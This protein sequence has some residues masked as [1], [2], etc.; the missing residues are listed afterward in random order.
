V[1]SLRSVTR[2][3][4]PGQG[5]TGQSCNN[6]RAI[7][8]SYNRLTHSK[9]GNKLLLKELLES[10]DYSLKKARQS[11][12]QRTKSIKANCLTRHYKQS[13]KNSYGSQN[14]G[15]SKELLAPS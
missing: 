9:L 3:T 7:S 13:H 2:E 12:L 6:K 5:L 14:L 8:T 1:P 11:L 15:L 10:K 4:G